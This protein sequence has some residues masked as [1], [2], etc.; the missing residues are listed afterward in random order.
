MA[1]S[2]MYYIVPATLL[3]KIANSLR[4]MMRTSATYTIDGMANLIGS[5]KAILANSCGEHLVSGLSDNDFTEI[6]NIRAYGLYKHD[7]T[8]APNFENL[9]SIGDYGCYYSKF[10][11]VS[12]PKLKTIGN[13]AFGLCMHISGVI[14]LPMIETIGNRVFSSCTYIRTLTFGQKPT[15]IS[16]TAFSGSSLTTINCP[17]AEGEVAG[18]PWGATN[19]TINYNY[20]E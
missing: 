18:A 11:G 3:T 17:W 13:Y 12:L 2:L 10:T 5:N 4:K 15:S 7:Y 19:A 14:T 9:E 8:G 1:V 6:E 20:S 16:T